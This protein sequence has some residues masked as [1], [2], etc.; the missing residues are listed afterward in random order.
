MRILLQNYF[1]SCINY[2]IPLVYNLKVAIH[3]PHYFPYPGFF[4]KLSQADV[5]V[6]MDKTQYD[7]RF[8]NRN[9]IIT[10]T[11]WTW[12]TV[13][14]NKKHKF[15]PNNQVKI[16]NDLA[17]REDHW[18]MIYH[19]YKGSR[20][21][22]LYENYLKNL[23]EKDWDYLFSLDLETTKQVMKWLNINVEI[24]LESELKSDG[25]SSERLINICSELG[26]DTYVSGIG[27]KTY[28]NE[29]AFEKHG[30]S[31]QYDEFKEPCYPQHLSQK[32][33][34]SLSIIDLL[35]NLGDHA[36]TIVNPCVVLD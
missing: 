34:P 7:K 24:I 13:P 2:K 15:L 22:H 25:Q 21:F 17:W 4:H 23:Y 36:S 1:I 12:I 26:A 9:R 6:I 18:K 27:A 10:N 30:I 11:G 16:N 31:V 35:C 29:N 33:I 5:F 19:S 28:Q 32:Y 3:Q 20:F 8:T 14:I